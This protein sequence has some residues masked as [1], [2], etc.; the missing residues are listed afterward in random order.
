MPRCRGDLIKQL[1]KSDPSER[2]AMRPGGPQNIKSHKWFEGWNWEAMQALK[3]DPPYKPVVKS[4]KDLANF[5]AR[6]ED[7]PRQL[8]YKDPGTGWD[9]DFATA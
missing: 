9:K 7:M 6:K 2:L 4:K 1:L 5:S 3:L 8:E